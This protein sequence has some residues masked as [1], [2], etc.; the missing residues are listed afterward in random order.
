MGFET[1]NS[2][3]PNLC[4]ASTSCSIVKSGRPQDRKNLIHCVLS[5]IYIFFT[6]ALKSFVRD[7]SLSFTLFL[8]MQKWQSD[9]AER[10]KIIL[11]KY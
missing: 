3:F 10:D 11:S 5:M 6:A 1:V 2:I 4:L 9:E 7:V 8:D